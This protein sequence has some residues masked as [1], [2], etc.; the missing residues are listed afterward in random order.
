MYTHEGSSLLGFDNI[1]IMFLLMKSTNIKSINYSYVLEN[2]KLQV[3]L[4]N[5]LSNVWLLSHITYI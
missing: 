1:K 3:V 5:K 4:P 2:H